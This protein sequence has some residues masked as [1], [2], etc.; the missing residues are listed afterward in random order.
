[1]FASA[2]ESFGQAG[3]P[4]A[5]QL[6]SPSGNYTYL[7]FLRIGTWAVPLPNLGTSWRIA[8]LNYWNMS[9]TIQRLPAEAKSVT[10]SIQA[11]PASVIITTA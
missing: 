4:A 9:T 11:R 3:N 8:H 10:L 2:Q 7:Y 6:A 1:M 5:Q